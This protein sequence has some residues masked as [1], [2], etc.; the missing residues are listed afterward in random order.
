MDGYGSEIW[1]KFVH[2]YINPIGFIQYRH[3]IFW[4][5]CISQSVEREV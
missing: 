1:L 5:S 2:S 4:I 3:G